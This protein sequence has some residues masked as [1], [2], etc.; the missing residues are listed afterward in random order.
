MKPLLGAVGFTATI[1]Q[2]VLLRE[3]L[4]VF[5]G[6]ELLFGLVFAAWL[7]WTA[8]GARVL[9]PVLIRRRPQG[10]STLAACLALAA[11]AFPMQIA[12][13]RSIRLVSG[14]TPGA[15]V[16]FAVMAAAIALLVAPLCL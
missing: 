7:L 1:A 13:V 15:Q 2:L 8:A 6:N 9:G 16:E 4:A 3:M 10:T 14:T 12:L 11:L 5:Y